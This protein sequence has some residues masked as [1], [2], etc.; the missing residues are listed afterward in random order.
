MDDF[1]IDEQTETVECCPN[2][3]VPASSEHDAQ[4]GRTRTVMN[5]SDCSACAFRRDCPVREVRG[6]FVLEHSAAHINT[7]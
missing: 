3:C 2:G 7:A 4:R 5:G 1:V 6:Q